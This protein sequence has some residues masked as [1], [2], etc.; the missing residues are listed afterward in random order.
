MTVD[1]CVGMVFRDP[2]LLKLRLIDSGLVIGWS[3]VDGLTARLFGRVGM[4][5]F[6][7]WVRRFSG[8]VVDYVDGG[9]VY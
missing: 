4:M 7:S 8:V 9:T 3:V 5:L 1:H 2:G 6:L